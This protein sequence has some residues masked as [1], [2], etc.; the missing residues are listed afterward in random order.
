MLT[1][2]I[3]GLGLILVS[4]SIVWA[5]KEISEAIRDPKPKP[6]ISRNLLGQIKKAQVIKKKDD[7]DILLGE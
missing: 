6:D 4:I 2:I 1:D 5:S 7:I 3:I